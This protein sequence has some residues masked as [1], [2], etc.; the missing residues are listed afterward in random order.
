MNLLTLLFQWCTRTCIQL[1]RR[2]CATPH[3]LCE[4]V[5]THR[6]LTPVSPLID[7]F[8]HGF[9]KCTTHYTLLTHIAPSCRTLHARIYLHSRA[10]ARRNRQL[11]PQL[12]IAHTAIHRTRNRE[13]RLFRIRILSCMRARTAESAHLPLGWQQCGVLCCVC[14]INFL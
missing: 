3:T 12:T 10:Q 7:H 14:L 9:T 5:P 2:V 13:R 6:L 11:K 8:S 1:C 4:A